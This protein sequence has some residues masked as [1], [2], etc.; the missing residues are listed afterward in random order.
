MKGEIVPQGAKNEALQVIAAVLLTPEKV[1]IHN[2]PDIVDV[3]N[4][5]RLL[6]DLGVEI[7]QLK[8]GSYTFQAREVDLDFM[9]S[10]AF[11]ARGS[12]NISMIRRKLF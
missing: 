9:E 6:G 5:I 7:H 12:G 1:V 10:E 11:H 4:L 8:E 3:N 2:I